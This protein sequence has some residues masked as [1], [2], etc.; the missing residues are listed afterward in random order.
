MLV[1]TLMLSLTTPSLAAAKPPTAGSSPI[2]Q[3]R[4]SEL[5]E[6]L[7]QT[8]AK[9]LQLELQMAKARH[10]IADLEQPAASPSLV[11]EELSEYQLV[12][13][14]TV[15]G[16]TQIMLQRDNHVIQL[17]HGVA[18]P[19]QLKAELEAGWVR[20]QRFGAFRDLPIV[21]GW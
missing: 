21:Q 18:G 3:L 4:H 5:A 10:A 11:A 1:L 20:L 12:G 7:A 13:V 8:E 16:Q 14:V 15:S 19:M 17:Q 9:R 6:R 2:Q